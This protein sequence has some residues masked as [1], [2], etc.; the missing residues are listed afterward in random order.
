MD[1]SRRVDR[2]NCSVRIPVQVQTGYQL[3]FSSVEST[4]QVIHNQNFSVQAN[5]SLGVVGGKMIQVKTS[6]VVNQTGIL[7]ISQKLS[8]SNLVVTPCGHEAMLVIDSAVT[9]ISSTG[10]SV[11]LLDATVSRISTQLNIRKCK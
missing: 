8:G 2:K 6:Q 9:A 7:S 10:K 11:G 5:L 1:G 3:V 4:A